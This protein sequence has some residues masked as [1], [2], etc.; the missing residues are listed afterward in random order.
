M[1]NLKAVLVTFAVL[2]SIG[3]SN[4]QHTSPSPEPSPSGGLSRRPDELRPVDQLTLR[5]LNRPLTL[6]GELE[7]T[8]QYEQDF[9]LGDSQDDLFRLSQELVLEFS[10]PLTSNVLLFVEGIAFYESDLYAEDVH[11]SLLWSLEL[12]Q[13]WVNVS[14]VLGSPFGLQ[15]GRQ[16]FWEERTWWWDDDL[17]AVRLFYDVQRLYAELAVL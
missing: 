14:N 9:T 4:A 15:I 13:A 12:G 1:T 16:G 11:R 10:Y 17:D 8:L 6:G 7:N 5:L 2:T 3:V